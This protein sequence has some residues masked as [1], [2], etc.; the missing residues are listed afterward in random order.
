MRHLIRTIVGMMMLWV[1]PLLMVQGQTAHAAQQINADQVLCVEWS[2]G[3]DG[4]DI[5]YDFRNNVLFTDVVGDV[6]AFAF[7][8]LAGLCI[9]VIV[10]A[11]F[12]L[13]MG[14]YSDEMYQRAI[15]AIIYA[16]V[17]LMVSAFA[18]FIVDGLSRLPFPGP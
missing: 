18:F 8:I 10:V 1:M 15:R 2:P 11:G 5:E 9:F 7:G 13:L 3:C 12:M 6:I 17:G 16:G 14:G 4:G